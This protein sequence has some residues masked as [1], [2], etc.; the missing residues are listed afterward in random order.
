MPSEHAEVKTMIEIKDRKFPSTDGTHQLVGKMYIPETQPRAIFHVVHGMTEHIGRYEAFLTEMAENGYLCVAYDNLGHGKTA[1]NDSELGYIA[2]KDGWKILAEDVCSTSQIIKK[3]YPGLKYYLMGHSMGSF[4]VRLAV[5]L[6][7]ELSD[8]L[9]VM[10]TGGPNPASGVALGMIDLVIARKGDRA[11]SPWLENL[12]FGK[13]N[14]RFGG[15]VPGDW[16]SKD[17]EVRIKYDA[18][19]FCNFHFTVSALRD[20]VKLNR[21]VNK[22]RVFRGTRASLPILLLSGADDPVGDYGK[23]VLRVRRELSKHVSD[24]R[25]KLYKNNRHE[26]L[27]DTARES[28]I[29]DILAFC[30]EQ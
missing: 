24:V 22:K 21:T 27:N 9:I 16:L 15:D 1:A 19:R 29:E 26:I 17:P 12:A 18:D 10:G 23:G 13:Y 25:M 30:N 28:V 5:W 7:P 3:E 6:H 2:K 4:I 20:L 11:Y 14:E 8:K